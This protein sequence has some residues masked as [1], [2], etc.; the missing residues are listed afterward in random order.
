MNERIKAEVLGALIVGCILAAVV[1]AVRLIIPNE[2][3]HCEPVAACKCAS[4][5]AGELRQ[6]RAAVADLE[7][8]PEHPCQCDPNAKACEC[9]PRNLDPDQPG[10]NITTWLDNA[11]GE[12]VTE[13]DTDLGHFESRKPQSP[14]NFKCHCS[15]DKICDCDKCDCKDCPK[16]PK[17][18][19][20]PGPSCPEPGKHAPPAAKQAPTFILPDCR[21]IID[22]N[23]Y[24]FNGRRYKQRN[25]R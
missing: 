10:R 25:Y 15:L 12:Q 6:L 7:S 3:C 21:K 14:E 22:P 11:T 24:E 19:E 2:P 4:T 8:R 17:S 5:T 13:W 9:G 20:L 1:I 18:E 23:V 16:H